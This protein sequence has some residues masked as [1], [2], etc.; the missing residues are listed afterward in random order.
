MRRQKS[1]TTIWNRNFTL[2]LLANICVSTS[3]HMISTTMAKYCIEIG[4]TEAMAGT[5]VGIFSIASLCIRPF[6]GSIIDARN[7]KHIYLASL[8]LLVAV[9]ALYGTA[10]N[11]GVLGALRFLHGFGF[12]FATTT[13]LAMASETAPEGRVGSAL[14]MYGIASSVATALAPNLG[15]AVAG[16]KGFPAMFLTAAVIT[17]AACILALPV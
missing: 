13:G 17:V 9:M 10:V 4:T 8:G 7:K 16:A 2:L 5:I 3:F 12:G 1:N 11:M 6:C 15:L 14:G